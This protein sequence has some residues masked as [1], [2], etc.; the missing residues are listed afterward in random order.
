ML[1]D[2]EVDTFIIEDPDEAAFDTYGNVVSQN[3]FPLIYTPV[4]LST[5]NEALAPVI[6]VVQKALEAPGTARFLVGLYNGGR[7]EYLRHK[8]FS[9]FSDEERRY[10]Q[11]H[12]AVAFAAE[13]GN[14]PISFYNVREKQWHGIAI[15]VLQ[16]ISDL[17]GLRFQRVNNE[18]AD[19]AEILKMLE[20]GKASMI[21]EL[22]WSSTREGNFLWSD[23]ALMI[24]NSAL[25]SRSDYPNIQ[26]NEIMYVKVGLVKDYAHTEL[27][28]LWFPDHHNTVEYP[29]TLAAFNA[30]E[31]GEV[32]MVMTSNHE[33]L[34][35]SHYME[36]VGFKA[37]VVFDYVFKSTFGF[38][39]NETD[40][41]SIVNKSMRLI[42]TEFISG[43]WMRQTYDYRAN[44][45]EARLPWLIGV[46]ALLLCVIMLM[47]MM[48]SR[49][50]HLGRRLTVLVDKRTRELA[51][52]TREAENASE[53][54]SRFIANMSHEMRTPMNVIVGLTDL[55]MEEAETPPKTKET[56][57]KI[58]VAGST[59]M[60]LI[61]DVLDISKIETGKMELI[62]VQYDVASTLNDIITLNVIRIKERP[63]S[64][65]LDMSEDLPSAL[66][67]DDLRVKQIL[68]NLLSNAFKYTKDGT[69]TLGI[70]SRRENEYVWLSFFVQDTGI[71]IREEDVKKLFT[72]YNQVDTN[73]NR[74]LDGSGLGLRIT[75][76][77]VE[78][79]CG[80]ISAESEF[81]KGSTFRFTI[82]QGFVNDTPIGKEVLE[83]LKG[84]RYTDKKKQVQAKLVRPDLSY[85]RALIVDDF[86]TN[87]DVASGM[88]RKYKMQVDCVMSGQE[89]IDR[90][91]AGEPIY[92]AIFM[93]HMMPVMDG[94]EATLK[95]R[96]LGTDYA[97]N[98]PVIALTANAVAGSE[99]MFLENGFNVFLPK[100]LNVMALDAVVQ[101]WIRQKSKENEQ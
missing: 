39:K 22:M 45:A 26:P 63:V 91:A 18:H 77:F 83:N 44:V 37:N 81:G 93:D 74:E 56:L 73:A 48:F 31:R 36:R 8:L 58:S 42:D 14:Y 40:L 54:K 60:A 32:D 90:I 80:E 24:D 27:F 35:L 84:F 69:V 46:A 49:Q 15:E 16:E 88:L 7:R 19:W 3:F 23:T 10:V 1:K 51:N 25:I 38:N 20:D 41:R 62:P 57:Q 2:G 78:L 76:K 33:L 13:T 9:Q 72:D 79:M 11:N 4:S 61:N 43:R 50:R 12:E 92:N 101:R 82:R 85:A 100:P 66:F 29:S 70:S 89:A 53:A 97:K 87:L 21:T 52:I 68:N 99:Q 98:I 94:V 71:G 67:G 30:L 55:M 6:S 5:R 95:I 59:L 34:I 96:A 17:T 75:K 65:R 64:F 47:F 28:R 86:P